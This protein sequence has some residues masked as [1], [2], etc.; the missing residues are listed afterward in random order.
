MSL[1]DIVIIAGGVGIGFAVFYIVWAYA[2]GLREAPRELWLTSASRMVAWLMYATFTIT[3]V[4]WLSSDCG[5]GDVEA[6][7]YVTV[8]SLA[9]SI[10]TILAG[11]L[12]DA[13]GI[14][15]A[16]LLSAVILF[17][18]LLFPFWLTHP[19]LLMFLAMVPFACGF[20]T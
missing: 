19:V 7:L 3:F 2:K 10:F 12:V 6:G 20:Y 14:K 18:S 13:I 4:L 11:P 5:L 15:K 8:W 9:F 17:I 1:A 16:F